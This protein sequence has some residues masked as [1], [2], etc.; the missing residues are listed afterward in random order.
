MIKTVSIFAT[1]AI[2]SITLFSLED[3]HAT[4]FSEDTT[5]QVVY[6]TDTQVCSNYEYQMA[7]K[8]DEITDKYFDLYEFDN[9]KYEPL[10]MNNNKFDALYEFPKD[11]DLIILVYNTNLGEVELHSNK[12]GGVFTH[13]GPDRSYNNA[14]I[15]CDCSNFYYSD[16][17]WIL[18]HELSHF[19][20]YYLQF[21]MYV[22][23]DLVHKYDDKYDACRENYVSSCGE[24]MKKIRVD[25]M[26]Y[27]FSVMPPYE[28]AIGISKITNNE[29]N[30]SAP[31]LELGKAMTKWW[32]EGK[33]TEG[34]YSNALGL[35]AVQNQQLTNDDH[36]V[37]FKD[38][39]IKDEV[40]W[41][42]VLFADGSSENK[43]DVMADVTGKL[44]IDES[45]YQQTDF[46]GLPDWF[47]QIAQ[48]WVDG[49]IT[50]DE[51]VRNVKFLKDSGIIR[52][53]LL[54]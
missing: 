36:Q 15:I 3:A 7:I 11:L 20:L 48:W 19:V 2:I 21:D 42:E 53:H 38:G 23:E 25:K 17:V 24:Y 5:W 9:T 28:F 54:E 12:M 47:K 52:D 43:V 18:T 44:K 30:V 32:A 40:G 26:A 16:P 14:I 51:F 6:L 1:I 29:V 35:L 10:C 34:D 33:I 50:D 37:L 41:E 45:I 22:I 27:S 4:H 39:P 13:S 46:T 31:M 49:D 8:Y